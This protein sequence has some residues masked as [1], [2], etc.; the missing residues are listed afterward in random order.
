MSCWGPPVALGPRVVRDLAARGLPVR[1]V[2]R[3]GTA[4]VP[5]GVERVAADLGTTAGVRRACEG[6]AVVYHCAQ[7]GCTKWPEL[8][9][10]MTQAILDGASAAGAKLVFAD[11]VHVYGLPTAR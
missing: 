7:P 8:F 2:T 6:A 1:A 4:D 9:P 5:D 10:P 3:G 11:G